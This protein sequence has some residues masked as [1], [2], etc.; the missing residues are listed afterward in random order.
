V[1]VADEEGRPLEKC[2]FA[3]R[4]QGGAAAIRG[5]LAPAVG[6][7]LSHYS[8]CALGVGFGGP[9]DAE[10]GRVAVSHQVEGWAEFPLRDWLGD[11]TGLSVVVEN[12]TNAAALAEALQ[13]A[14]Q[15]QRVVFYTNFGS[16]MGGGLVVDGRLYHGAAPGE[17]EL[18]LTL[19]D[20]SGTSFE[21]RCCGW[22]V[23]QKVRQHLDQH[24]D[25]LLARLHR[26][27]ADEATGEARLLSPALAAGD[28]AA[29]AI[30]EE[31]ADDIAFALSHVTHLLHPDVLVLGG[32]L[33]L[34][35]EP[36]REAIASRLPGYLAPV[37]RPGPPVKLAALGEEVVCLGALLLARGLG[38]AS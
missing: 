26:E 1:V 34:I 37:F 10:T 16:G 13:G 17:A 36:F 5:Q 11:L 30:L 28:G 14:G 12:D 22:A 23:D 15:A 25:S 7:A 29:R 38:G 31:T 4:R 18:G 19:L 35:G 2:R 6:D 8:P 24:P 32:G 20:K 9:V 21:S 33:S 3:A 27:G